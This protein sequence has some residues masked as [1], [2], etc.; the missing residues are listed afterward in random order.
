MELCSLELKLV[1]RMAGVSQGE[2]DSHVQMLKV[3]DLCERNWKA[4]SV[5]HSNDSAGTTPPAA[6]GSLE[7]SFKFVGHDNAHKL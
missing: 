1:W 2:G 6:P 7:S 3:T 5:G 4:F